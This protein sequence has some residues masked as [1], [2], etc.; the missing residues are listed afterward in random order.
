MLVLFRTK[1]INANMDHLPDN[2]LLNI[3][4]HLELDTLDNVEHVCQRWSF[5]AHTPELWLFKCKK[6]C[7]RER[8]GQVEAL[9]TEASLATDEIDWKQAFIEISEFTA[10]ESVRQV[11]LSYLQSLKANAKAVR[12]RNSKI[13]SSYMLFLSK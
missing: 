9:I 10:S 5:L 12:P 4:A 7:E 8:L 2:V 11:R 13:T 3:F 6:L 1:P